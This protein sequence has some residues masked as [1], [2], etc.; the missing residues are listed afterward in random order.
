[1]QKDNDI[2][3]LLNEEKKQQY[4]EVTK[5][6]NV[7]HDPWTNTYYTDSQVMYNS[8]EA[9]IDAWQLPTKACKTM[10]Y[11]G[12]VQVVFDVEKEE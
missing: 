5:W 4:E 11:V 3:E 8:R 7:F 1:M 2:K 9:A 6:V 12:T 10:R